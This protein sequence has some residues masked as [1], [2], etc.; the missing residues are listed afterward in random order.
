MIVLKNAFLLLA[1]I[2]DLFINGRIG[3]LLKPFRKEGLRPRINL[4]HSPTADELFKDAVTVQNM[5]EKIR[6]RTPVRFFSLDLSPGCSLEKKSETCG[7]VGKCQVFGNES[8]LSS[9]LFG[10]D[11]E[12]DKVM[13]EEEG[14]CETKKT[15]IDM[16]KNPPSNTEYKGGSVWSMIYEEIDKL[17]MPLLL[18]LTSGVQSNIAVHASERYKKI[19]ED[20]FEYNIKNFIDKFSI[21]EE[22]GSNLLFTFYYLVQSMCVLGEKFDEFMNKNLDENPENELLKSEIRA[23]LDSESYYSCRKEYMDDRFFSEYDL[24]KLSKFFETFI[25]TL[26]CVECEKCILHGTIKGNAL[27]LATKALG[28]KDNFQVDPLAFVTYI[29]G[30][31]IFSSSIITIDIFSMRIK[32]YLLFLICTIVF[33]VLAY[34]AIKL[35]KIKRKNEVKAEKSD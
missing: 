31:Y 35:Y 30:L 8:D 24:P 12:T 13:L 6:L 20:K 18:N 4:N 27:Y 7:N 28:K 23:L 19:R 26:G 16:L 29:N 14:D 25:S 21:Y 11:M 17:K 34:N 3:Y 9:T 2:V 1:V 32:H 33:S 15:K 10:F 5:M 22:R